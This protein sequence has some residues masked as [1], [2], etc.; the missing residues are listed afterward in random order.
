MENYKGYTNFETYVFH[1]IHM[2]KFMEMLVNGEKITEDY[3][4]SLVSIPEDDEFSTIILKEAYFKIDF[5][6]LVE[7]YDIDNWNP[8]N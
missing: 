5:K 8:E 4:K 3:M 7:Q 6:S 1:N 2:E